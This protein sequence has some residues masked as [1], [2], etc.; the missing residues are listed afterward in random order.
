LQNCSQ[1]AEA[2]AHRRQTFTPPRMKSS[3]LAC[4]FLQ[5]SGA[6]RADPARGRRAQWLD[7]G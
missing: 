5:V 1:P 7:G 4:S 6:R 3:V 2:R